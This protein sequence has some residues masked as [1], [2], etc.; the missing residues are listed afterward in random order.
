[1][2]DIFAEDFTQ[3]TQ[4]ERHVADTWHFCVRQV[5][6]VTSHSS[7]VVNMLPTCCKLRENTNV[8]FMAKTRESLQCPAIKIA[9]LLNCG[10]FHVTSTTC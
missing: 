7:R 3:G 5:R 10:A 2:T 8:V 6:T 9:T 1:M 4:R